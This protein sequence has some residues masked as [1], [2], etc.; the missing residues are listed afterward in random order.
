MT[1]E[2]SLIPLSKWDS[3]LVTSLKHNLPSQPH[4]MKSRRF[5]GEALT[6]VTGPT[7]GCKHKATGST[8]GGKGF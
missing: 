4:V 8:S 6:T 7:C 2:K 5:A 3:I 1:L